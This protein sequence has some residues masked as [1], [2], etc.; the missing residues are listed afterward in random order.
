MVSVVKIFWLAL[1]DSVSTLF[2]KF[3]VFI[4]LGISIFSEL[5]LLADLLIP[6]LTKIIL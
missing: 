6:I 4:F 1:F 3:E 5:L 2:S